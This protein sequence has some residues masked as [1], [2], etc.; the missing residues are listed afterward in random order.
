MSFPLR[1]NR[2]II[3][4][5]FCSLVKR[6]TCIEFKHHI[7]CEK[8]AV[9]YLIKCDSCGLVVDNLW[10]SIEWNMNVVIC[11]Y[12]CMPVYRSGVCEVKCG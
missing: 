6:L 7:K 3:T 1:G 4:E 12:M 11:V 5:Y 2:V 10:I 9:F 8:R